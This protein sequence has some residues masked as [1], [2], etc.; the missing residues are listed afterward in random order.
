MFR[1]S[2]L[3]A[4]MA[5][6]S[7]TQGPVT[8]VVEL[9][10]ELKA[11]IEADGKM[12]QTIYDKYACW[13]E[14]TSARKASDIHTA[15]SDIKSLSTKIL[16][17][18]GL[19]ATRTSEIAQDS[20][21]INDNQ[22]AQDE[23][24]GIRQKENAAYMAEKTEMETT[25]N[26]LQRGI[27]VMSGAGT[28]TALLQASPMDEM[29]LLSVAAGVHQA[30]KM[31][32]NDHVISS[33]ELA[34][35]SN[36]AKDPAEFYDQKAEKAASYNPASATIMGILKDMYDTFSMNLEKATEVE[37][38]AQKNYESLIGVKENEMATLVD[39]R[40][41]KEGEKAEAEKDLADASQ[42]LDDTTKQMKADTIFFD[43]TKAACQAKADEW[44]ERVRA[45]TEELAGINKALEI[46]TGD[47]AKA[48]FN[49][50]IKP[51]KETFFMQIDSESQPQVKAYKA[52]KEHATKAK[53]LRLAA[54]A[55]TL[56]TG[57]H[58]DAVIAEIDKMMATLKEEEKGDITQRDWCKEETFKN[59]QEASRY[60]YKIERTDAK[61][62]KLTSKLEELEGT[63][64]ATIASILATK[65][66]IKA[67]ED[68]RKEQHA[69]FESAKSDDEGAVKLLAAAIESMSAFYKNNKIDQGEIQGAAQAL[70]QQPTF[71]VSAD[72][73][74]DATFTSAGKS[75][76]ESK[77]IVSIM[78]MI[79]EDL[80]DEIS[81]GVKDE[82]ET[83][84]KFEEQLGEANT[85]LEELKAK[86]TNLEQAI[87]D[88]NTEIDEN[89]V[90]KEDLQG[91]L[92]EEKDYLA[93]I[94]PD[95]DWILNSFTERRT[96]R[97]AEMEGLLQAKGMLAGASPSMVQSSVE[98]DDDEF[99]NMQFSGASFLQKSK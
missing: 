29:T 47:D 35:V 76:G 77:G 9:I 44:A 39:A 96:K 17:L 31:L 74:P 82:G 42:E 87:S 86:K 61:I 52:L 23:A 7:A 63:L 93:S 16:E 1:A 34:L 69:A 56:R 25:L 15:M 3:L 30:I 33:K 4:I 11:K 84:A 58:F 43:E 57:G 10:E 20:L 59:E 55:A 91:L 8:K 19:V 26:A 2:C 53:S 24:T 27:E 54:I 70:I 94:K 5:C 45:R 99:P 71:E 90:K 62:M 60:E 37:A 46:L 48:L 51:G 21:E 14:T 95:C 98:F 97:A 40:K 50:A 80:E 13:C 36:F 81:N 22:Q 66:D 65:D 38:V 73:A 41:K 18:K 92:K 72:Q 85:L 49:K 67:M 12:E 78:T 88:T 83:Q 64:Q 75:G 32:P 28:K 79:K 6:A 89:E 68:A